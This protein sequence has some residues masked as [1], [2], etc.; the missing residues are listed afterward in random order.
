[1]TLQPVHQGAR[2]SR[3]TCAHRSGTRFSGRPTRD[4]HRSLRRLIL[5]QRDGESST[6]YGSES[7][8]GCRSR[9]LPTRRDDSSA[10]PRSA[11][12][13]VVDQ[14]RP[15]EVRLTLTKQQQTEGRTAARAPRCRLPTVS[16]RRRC[17]MRGGR[18]HDHGVLAIPVE[19]NLAFARS[20][21]QVGDKAADRRC[22]V[23]PHRFEVDDEQT[24]GLSTP[25]TTWCAVGHG[26]AAP[27]KLVLQ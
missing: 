25:V 19:R 16:Q 1:M 23:I 18:T 22:E 10:R 17:P 20:C 21:F 27:R 2:R 8:F 3:S 15:P 13:V 11:V 12:L 14:A 9:R 26:H 5:P 24:V 4:R 7:V 6:S